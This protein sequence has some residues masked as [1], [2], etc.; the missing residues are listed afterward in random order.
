MQSKWTSQDVLELKLGFQ[1]ENNLRL[2][3]W[4]FCKGCETLSIEQRQFSSRLYEY[5]L[6]FEKRLQS[7]NKVWKM[8]GTDRPSRND[9]DS[10]LQTLLHANDMLNIALRQSESSLLQGEQRQLSELSSQ[11][12]RSLDSFIE[13]SIPPDSMST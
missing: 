13:D 10:H 3:Y 2:D 1:V 8:L 7:A 6:E 12:K 4:K 11:L 9:L 5:E